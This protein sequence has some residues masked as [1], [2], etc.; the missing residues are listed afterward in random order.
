MLF[1]AGCYPPSAGILA[2]VL[3]LHRTQ[4]ELSPLL[5]FL[6]YPFVQLTTAVPR[7]V[8]ELLC[9]APQLAVEPP[10]IALVPTIL[11]PLS[12]APT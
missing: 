8:I 6:F 9:T 5:I 1:L 11:F 4:Q 10:C 7:L 2:K 3:F 12:Q